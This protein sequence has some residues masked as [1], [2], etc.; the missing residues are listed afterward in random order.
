MGEAATAHFPRLSCR[1]APMLFPN[2]FEIRE[3]SCGSTIAA[4]D[5]RRVGSA[6]LNEWGGSTFASSMG[7][8]NWRFSMRVKSVD[9]HWL[10]GGDPRLSS[11]PTDSF[12]SHLT[13]FS[14]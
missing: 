11:S 5:F 10:S 14:R 4:L 6:E 7:K 8:K 1:V 13:N 2:F 9:R 12:V 3:E